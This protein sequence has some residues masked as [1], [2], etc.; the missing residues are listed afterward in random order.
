[1]TIFQRRLSL[2]VPRLIAVG[3]LLSTLFFLGLYLYGDLDKKW[4]DLCVGLTAGLAVAVIQFSWD[5]YE[6]QESEN[7]RKLRVRNVL[8]SRDDEQ[9]YRKLI[10][11]SHSRILV[12]GVTA[13]RFLD[14]FA[15]DQSPRDDKK[16]L[17]QAMA[18]GV[19]VRILVPEE[20]FVAPASKTMFARAH[21]S[22]LQ[23]KQ[24]FP[25]QFDHGYF[26]HEPRNSMVVCDEEVIV[27]PSFPEKA[28]KDTP[29]IHMHAR[30][31]FARAY[32]EHFEHEWKQVHP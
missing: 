21:A 24:R 12:L 16:V 22:M 13:S 25:R 4:A 27:G 17:V 19:N 1:M 6:A 23:L 15:D 28:S 30:S 9:Y 5:W 7:V 20:R 29:G 10:R 8:L 2:P 3:L 18:R 31:P 14:D 11:E 32:L 26:T